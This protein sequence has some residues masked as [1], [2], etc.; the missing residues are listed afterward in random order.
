M[1]G[2][3]PG[4][5]LPLRPRKTRTLSSV[6]DAS[7][8]LQRF[9]N[10]TTM[11]QGLAGLLAMAFGCGVDPQSEQE[12]V[13]LEVEDEIAETIENLRF[14]GNPEDEIE[15][16]ED[17]TVVLGGDAVVTLEASREMIGHAGHDEGDLEFRQYRSTNL[18]SATV[19]VICINGS[20]LTGQLSTALDDSIASYTDLN[21]SFNIVRTT[22]MA[23]GCD[24]LIT[25]SL[26]D[27][28]GASA[29]FPS[30]GMPYDTVLMGDDVLPTVGLAA[31]THVMTHE[32][33]HCIG[34]RHA[35]YYDRSISC[36]GAVN[37]EGDAGLGAI[38]I[39]GTPNT[40]SGNGSVM[41]ACYNAGSTGQWTASDLTAL[42]TQYP[43]GLLGAP[44][45]LSKVS[46]SCFGEYWMD[47]GSQPAAT[48]YQLWRST[49]AGFGSPV[50][51][52]SGASTETD[53]EVTSSAW[54]LRARAC[55]AG[56]CGPWTNQVSAIRL[57]HCS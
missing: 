16:R 25:F 23:A 32:L 3:Q 5:E 6:T 53:I 38:H 9:V 10:T 20:A 13:E 30:G 42:T 11:K 51:V 35:D 34:F 15:V 45:S 4:R 14:A 43:A 8:V 54:Y 50:M 39:P 52:Y 40:A 22:G 33:G 41:N 1:M 24:A 47:W 26:V 55:N 28:T 17:G 19:D 56:G 18:V 2:W 37:N 46:G 31:A 48:S 29:G 49:S 57:N 7:G 12:L 27:G 21:L 44:G 36:G